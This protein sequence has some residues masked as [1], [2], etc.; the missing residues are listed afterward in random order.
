MNNQKDKT[1]IAGVIL[2]ITASLCCITPV[3]ALLS[4]ISGIAATFSW[5]EPARPFLIGF[6][7]FILGFAWYQKLK[8]RKQEEIDCACEED[9]KPSFW[10]SRIFL[11]IV[12]IIAIGLLTFPSYSH[13]FYGKNKNEISGV[14][15]SSFAVASFSI[16]GMTCA[17]CEEHVNHAVNQLQGVLESSADYEDGTAEVKFNAAKLSVDKIVDAIN[18]TGYKVEKFELQSASQS[19]KTVRDISSF[20]PA[21]ISKM[22]IRVKGMTCNACEEHIKHAVNDL[23]GIIEASASY[24]EGIAIISYDASKISSEKIK[25]VINSTGYK[26]VD[27]E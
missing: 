7:V 16:N 11:G 6:T 21:T 12:T 5:L 19:N 17:G 24:K 23:D 22:E 26:V 20:E 3:L 15:E 8:P 13:I 10:Q 18:S 9:E 14:K 27:P 25:A 2:A 4:G 1:W